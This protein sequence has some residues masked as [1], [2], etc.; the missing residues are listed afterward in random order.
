MLNEHCN[1]T[2]YEI[3]QSLIKSNLIT[4]Q[5]VIKCSSNFIYDNTLRKGSDF[6]RVSF[7][8]HLHKVCPICKITQQEIYRKQDMKDCST[9]YSS[10][11][12]YW[13][14]RKD[15]QVELNMCWIIPRI[16]QTCMVYVQNY[17]MWIKNIKVLLRAFWAQLQVVWWLIIGELH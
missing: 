1:H 2:V 7:Q 5:N 17:W 14:L 16:S 15:I 13:N 9:K 4:D 10:M 3:H 6:K 8:C 11:N 12:I